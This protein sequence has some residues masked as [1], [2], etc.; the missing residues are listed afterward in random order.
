MLFNLLD[1][2]QRVLV[3]TKKLSLHASEFTGLLDVYC[4]VP[5]KDQHSH[6]SGH[7][8]FSES[9]CQILPPLLVGVAV[10]TFG[11]TDPCLFLD[12]ALMCLQIIGQTITAVFLIKLIPA[13]LQCDI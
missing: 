10:L 1:K 12:P 9:F 7:Y 2:T 8:L 3:N 6:F 5:I 13:S 11:L 4:L